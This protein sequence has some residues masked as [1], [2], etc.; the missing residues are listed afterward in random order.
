MARIAALMLSGFT[1]IVAGAA[2]WGVEQNACDSTCHTGAQVFV[3]SAVA[4]VALLIW[5]A[6]LAFSSSGDD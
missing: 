3:A 2:F 1:L 5:A 4:G 6:V